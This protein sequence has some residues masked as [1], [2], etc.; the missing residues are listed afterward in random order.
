MVNGAKGFSGDK[1]KLMLRWM[2]LEV[3]VKK[4]YDRGLKR[5]KDVIKRSSLQ[6]EIPYS[7]R[8]II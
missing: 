4:N 3:L 7:I 2:V 1:T 5:V 6:K 8:G